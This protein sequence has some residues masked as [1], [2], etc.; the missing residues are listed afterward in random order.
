[1]LAALCSVSL[2]TSSIQ[3]ALS[4]QIP[5]FGSKSEIREVLR[6][7][8]C[9]LAMFDDGNLAA[10]KVAQQIRKEHLK[11]VRLVQAGKICVTFQSQLQHGDPAREEA[12]LSNG[13]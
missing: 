4:V 11:S 3:A 13:R 10:P 1:M 5:L 9:L 8:F 6:W 2:V 7:Q 12:R